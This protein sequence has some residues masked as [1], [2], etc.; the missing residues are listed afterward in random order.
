MTKNMML[1][2]SASSL[3]LFGLASL[4]GCDLGESSPASPAG[5]PAAG[6]PAMG[7]AGAR[8][9][10]PAAGSGAGGSSAGGS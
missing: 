2:L 7:A 8:A 9:G 3:A 6:S 4:P 10:A 5:A 1:A